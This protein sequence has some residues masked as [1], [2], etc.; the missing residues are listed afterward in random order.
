MYNQ[1]MIMKKEHVN[2]SWKYCSQKISFFIFIYFLKKFTFSSLNENYILL[3]NMTY[4]LRSLRVHKEDLI[5]YF[6]IH[7][8]RKR[9]L[10][11]N[12]DPSQMKGTGTVPNTYR[13]KAPDPESL[14]KSTNLMDW[15]AG[16]S[17]G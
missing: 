1:I 11:R 9:I 5:C 14:M 12:C 8:R 13:S 3:D 17:S 2:S 7:D 10:I 15:S 16:I 6:K 4:R